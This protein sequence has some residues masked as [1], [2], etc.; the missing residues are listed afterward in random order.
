MKRNPVNNS[1]AYNYLII[2]CILLLGVVAF[3]LSCKSKSPTESSS[4]SDGTAAVRET[5]H[6]TRTTTTSSVPTALRSGKSQPNTSTIITSRNL[7]TTTTT[8]STTSI[9]VT[10][11]TSIKKVTTSIGAGEL[12]W[13]TF[14]VRLTRP[15]W[16]VNVN[17]GDSFDWPYMLKVTLSISPSLRNIGGTAVR[18]V[19]VILRIGGTGYY[20]FFNDS[21]QFSRIPANGICQDFPF[22]LPLSQLSR[23]ANEEQFGDVSVSQLPSPP[24]WVRIQL[25]AG[26]R[27]R[28]HFT[29][30]YSGK[31]FVFTVKR[32]EIEE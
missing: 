18:N 8:T 11:T 2:G 29:E 31:E 3:Y 23:M 24:I 17:N 30:S 13:C 15:P 9:P 10:T 22:I 27:L 7:T 4:P 26:E 21:V 25:D 32:L 12:E 1:K 16:E 6:A 20:Q 28:F 14:R 19:N 5:T